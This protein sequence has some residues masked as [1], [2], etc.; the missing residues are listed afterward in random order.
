MAVLF[1]S[2]VYIAV[3]RANDEPIAKLRA[4]AHDA[5]VWMSSVVLAELY[6]GAVGP[7]V[8]RVE[9]LEFHYRRC[10]RTLVPNLS[11]WSQTGG[12]LAQLGSKYGYEHIGKGRLTNDALIAVSAGRMGITVVTVNERD[13]RRLAEFRPFQWRTATALRA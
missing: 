3:L 6:A 10:G 1:D 2:S 12:V 11:D 7:D 5:V 8:G 13:F 9:R 4:A